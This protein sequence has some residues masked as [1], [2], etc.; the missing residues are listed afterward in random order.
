MRSAVSFGADPQVRYYARCGYSLYWGTADLLSAW[1][2]LADDAPGLDRILDRPALLG[3]AQPGTV[4]VRGDGGYS[5]TPSWLQRDEHGDVGFRAVDDQGCAGFYILD[6]HYVG[7][8][9]HLAIYPTNTGPRLNESTARVLF[10]MLDNPDLVDRE[11]TDVRTKGEL[12][13]RNKSRPDR[14]RTVTVVD[15]RASH[16]QAR[17]DVAEAERTYRSRWIVRGHW[18]QYW[19][20]PKSDRKLEP[21]YVM[22]YVKGPD[23]APL[24]VTTKVSRW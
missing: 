9:S 6:E 7:L 12:R 5:V 18:H 11:V 2:L 8:N 17:A 23:G 14:P 4:V 22:P 1:E 21:R 16:R 24:N 3:W 20:G 15:L 10:W 19:T 13:N